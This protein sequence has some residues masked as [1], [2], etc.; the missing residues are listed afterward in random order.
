MCCGETPTVAP[1]KNVL[2]MG[3][4]V[5]WG[6]VDRAAQQKRVGKE[7]WGWGTP[8]AAPLCLLDGA[9]CGVG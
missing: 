4:D 5:V 8:T 3:W 6:D 9:V 7:V 2:G 1:N